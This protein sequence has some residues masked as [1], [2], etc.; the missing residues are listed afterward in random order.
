MKNAGILWTAL[1][2]GSACASASETMTPPAAEQVFQILLQNIAL[3]LDGEPNCQQT[4]AARPGQSLTLGQHFATNLSV[5]YATDHNVTLLSSCLES[6]MELG[7]G[8]LQPVW[9]CKIEILEQDSKGEFI[10]SS[11]IAFYLTTDGT[12]L[13]PGTLRCF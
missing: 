11:M 6:K 3:P 7:D 5:S 10:S 2:A 13:L 4:S 1:I 8:K 12:A 9:D